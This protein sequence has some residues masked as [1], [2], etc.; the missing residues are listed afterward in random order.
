MKRWVVLGGDF[1]EVL[2]IDA[3]DKRRCSV[4]SFFRYST[5]LI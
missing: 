1:V 2:A 5:T 3:G 4:P